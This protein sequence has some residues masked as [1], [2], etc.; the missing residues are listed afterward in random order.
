MVMATNNQTKEIILGGVY[1]YVNNQNYVT[2]LKVSRVTEK[3]VFVFSLLSDGTFS[4]REH[5]EGIN[6]FKKFRHQPN[7][8]TK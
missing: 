5:R 7:F 3:S 6:S 4:T 2:V 1:S 8:F